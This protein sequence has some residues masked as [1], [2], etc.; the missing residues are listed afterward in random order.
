M[1][2]R[3]GGAFLLGHCTAFSIVA[4]VWLVPSTA[5]VKER[6]HTPIAVAMEKGVELRAS[7]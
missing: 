5:V 1:L 7:H 4:G 2:R 6:Y 3:Y